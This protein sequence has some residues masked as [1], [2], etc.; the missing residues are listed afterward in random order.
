M[1]ERKRTANIG[2]MPKLVGL[3]FSLAATAGV[4]LLVGVLVTVMLFTFAKAGVSSLFALIL[5]VITYVI[6]FTI[7]RK[8]GEFYAHNMGK[9]PV[10]GV[11]TG[12]WICSLYE[13]F[14]VKKLK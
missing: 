10:H 11:K 1:L 4:I 7:G 3:P 13:S 8:Y 5:P 2:R 14:L 12:A 6:C 9:K